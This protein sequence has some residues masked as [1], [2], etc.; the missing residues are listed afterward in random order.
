L[1]RAR[2]AAR[3]SIVSGLCV[4]GVLAL[5]ACGGGNDAPPT[6]SV[7]PG[8]DLRY[9][10]TDSPLLFGPDPLIGDQWHLANT[11]QNGGT[12]GEDLRVTAAWTITRG[13]GV[14]VAVVDD[15]VEILHTDLQ[16]NV[17][18]GASRSYRP[19]NVGGPWPLPCRSDVD[20]HGTAV[21]G[22]VLARDGNAAGG[23]GVAPRAGLV[24]FDALASGLDADIADALTR[25]ADTISIYQNSWG[26]P[27][28][29]RLHPSDPAFNA[30]IESGIA[31]GRGGRGSIFVFPGGN[32]GCYVRNADGGACQVD[33]ANLDGYVNKL[34]VIATCAVDDTGRSPWYGEPG[35]NL[36]VCAPSSGDRPIGITTTA[37]QSA[38]RSDFSGTSASTPMVSGVVA[39]MLA[40]NPD[41]SWRDV[42]LILAETARRNDPADPG[43]V[44]TPAGLAFNHKYGYGVVDAGAAVARAASWTTVGASRTLRT[45][46]IAERAPGL[47]LPDATEVGELFPV[48][49]V[50]TVADCGITRIEFVEM[51]FTATH[52]YSGDLRI[53]LTSPAGQ[54][55]E[56]A[57]ARICAGAGSDP[58]GA[59]TDW[60]FGSTRHLGESADGDWTLTVTD[61]APLDAGRLERWSLRIHG[62]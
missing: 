20:D 58:C 11:G 61:M 8:C 22:L 28:D 48:S 42:R 10:L 39:L 14:Q 53:S 51:R 40:A 15:A 37:L 56:L 5:S 21:A 2:A 54:V 52:T 18:P 32:G 7:G 25:G 36:L 3:S 13:A 19:G 50:V 33:N 46:T 31:T 49:D 47:P 24:A 35:A 16:P 41:L 55:S 59:F 30:A 38:Y 43:W 57:A 26:S 4:T 27:D 17:V 62:R 45:C 1:P 60:T 34:G 44:T 12:L 6:L 29:G 23:A 9:T